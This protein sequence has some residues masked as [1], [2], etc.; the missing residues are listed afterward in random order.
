MKKE[1]IKRWEPRVVPGDS[2]SMGRERRPQRTKF[3]R[4]G[5]IGANLLEPERV[6][7]G[8]SCQKDQRL[9]KD[10]TGFVSATSAGDILAG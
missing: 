10:E 7:N 1:K 3:V 6:L 8:R 4:S 5:E 2:D 9:M